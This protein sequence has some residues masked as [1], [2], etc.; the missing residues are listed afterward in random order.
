M[1]RR[2]ASLAGAVR[3]LSLLSELLEQFCQPL[4]SCPSK[5]QARAAALRA[6]C[7]CVRVSGHRLARERASI[8][9][10][11]VGDGPQNTLALAGAVEWEKQKMG[12]PQIFPGT[13]PPPPKSH[14]QAGVMISMML[15]KGSGTT[16]Q[17]KTPCWSPYR[18]SVL[19][20]TTLCGRCGDWPQF[21]DEETEARE[22]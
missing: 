7:L 6:V 16:C 11:L 21:S 10:L 9:F 2:S 18:N 14:C 20:S 15:R 8:W 12:D 4:H 17:S 19:F 5:T 1:S 22:G 3:P 13:N